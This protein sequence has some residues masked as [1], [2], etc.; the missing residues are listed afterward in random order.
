KLGKTGTGKICMKDGDCPSGVCGAGRCLEDEGVSKKKCET[1]RECGGG[2][3][4]KTGFCEANPKKNWFSLV[5]QQDFII[6][7]AAKDVCLNGTVYDCI[8]GNGTYYEPN[9]ANTLEGVDDEVKTGVGIA[10]TRLLLQYD[11][12]VTENIALGG[13]LGYAF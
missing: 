9:Q 4:C 10:T 6:L 8:Q 5:A 13:R 7:P 12:P 11:R 1:D 2:Y 3:L